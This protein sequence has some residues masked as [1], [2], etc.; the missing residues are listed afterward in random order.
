MNAALVRLQRRLPSRVR[1]PVR[2]TVHP[3]VTEGYC[4]VVTR[5]GELP[6]VNHPSARTCMKVMTQTKPDS[7]RPTDEPASAVRSP[8]RDHWRRKNSDP[9]TGSGPNDV[10]LR[11]EKKMNR[12]EWRN[13]GGRVAGGGR[14][15]RV[16]EK[17]RETHSDRPVFMLQE[18]KSRRMGV[19]ASIVAKKRS[20]ARGAKGC[21]KV[22]TQRHET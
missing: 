20:N 6:E 14:V 13:R 21:R 19:R 17:S 1:V 8:R 12:Q 11:P 7:A 22:E 10:R 4:V 3:P 2:R 15:E 9:Q 18:P 16:S 5:G